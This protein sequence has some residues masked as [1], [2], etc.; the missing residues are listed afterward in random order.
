MNRIAVIS[1]LA[2]SPSLVSADSVFLKSGGEVKGEVVEQRADAVVLEVGPGRITVPMK[3]VAR[4][5]SSTTDLGVYH[6]RAAALAPRDVQGWLSLA[7]WAQKH[8]LATQA[9]DAYEHVL[10]VDPTNADAHLALGNVR[11]GDRWVSGAEANRARGL[12]EFEGMW[13]SPEERQMRLEE[14]A[15]MAQERQAIREGDARAREAEARAREA[16]ARAEAAEADAR[17]ARAGMDNGGIPLGYGAGYGPAVYGGGYGPAVYGPGYGPFVPG[18]YDPFP[19]G[20]VT[21]RP[22]PGNS[23]GHRPPP[24]NRPDPPPRPRPQDPGPGPMREM[25]AH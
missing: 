20:V 15:A 4:I 12:V 19:G 24:F 3:N 25:P 6:A 17:Q 10:A 13:M 14:R 1:L 8:D 18:P 7:A 21:P 5:V 16:T 2:L 22:R 23:H 11:M 9:R